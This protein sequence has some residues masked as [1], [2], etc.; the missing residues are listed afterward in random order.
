MAERRAAGPGSRDRRARSS[1][2]LSSSSGL[3]AAAAFCCCCCLAL[4]SPGVAVAK[5]AGDGIEVENGVV[6]LPLEHSF[7]V[8]G[9]V[10]FRRRGTVI[11]RPQREHAVSISQ[12]P[13][14]D[15]ERNKLREVAE[16]DGLYRIRLPIPMGG[17]GSS[18]EY[19]FTFVRAC[20]LLEAQLSDLLTLHLDAVGAI[21][22]ISLEVVPGGC[23]GYEVEDVDLENF[24]TTLTVTTPVVL[25]GPET[26]SYIQ[27]LEQEQA[28]R[29]KNPQEQKSFFAKYWHLILGGAVL[30]MATGAV[31]PPPPPEEA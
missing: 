16:V 3:L 1:S 31:K 21:A 15:D 7:E 13:F 8:D 4:L 10:Q 28:Q 20:A 26:A 17:D 9:S 18:T 23:H 19:V 6:S 5:K 14:T 27:R 11:W 30:L 25:L 22:G 12:P 29:T 2:S 24:N